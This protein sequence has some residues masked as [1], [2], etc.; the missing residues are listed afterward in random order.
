MLL[1]IDWFRLKFPEAREGPI[2]AFYGN[3][4]AA[5]RQTPLRRCSSSSVDHAREASL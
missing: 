5:A 3:S 1:A 2:T 4:N